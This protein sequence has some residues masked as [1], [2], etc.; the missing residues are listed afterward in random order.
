MPWEC[1]YLERMP[2]P[3]GHCPKC[4]ASPFRSFLRGMIQRRQRK[5][6]FFGKLWPYCSIICENCKEIVGHEAPEQWHNHPFI[7][8]QP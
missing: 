8:E 4:G 5:W 1:S 6:W 7:K 2:E 3:M